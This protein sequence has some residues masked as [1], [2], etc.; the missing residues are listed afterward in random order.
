VLYPAVVIALSTGARKMEVLSLTWGDIDLRRQQFVIQDSKN[1]ERRTVPLVGKALEEV[2]RLWKV[3]RIDTALLFPRVDGQQP[4]DIRY[5]WRQA[6]SAAEITDFRFH[7][8]RHSAASYLAMHGASLIEL[9]DILG[10]KSLQ[11]VRRYAHLSEAH[12]ATVV[13]RM[14]A[15]VFE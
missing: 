2:Q 1:G 14:N 10:H 11:M 12:T 9:A 15:A 5:A 7:D 4:L 13:Q 6:L 3:R 8:L